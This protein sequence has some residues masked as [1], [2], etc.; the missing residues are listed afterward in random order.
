M[1][2]SPL[3]GVERKLDFESLRSVD[4]PERTM[5]VDEAR[6]GD[7]VQSCIPSINSRVN[8]RK[9]WGR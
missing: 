9:I 3:S 1:Y 6:I 5:W 4:D 8:E 2:L 7:L